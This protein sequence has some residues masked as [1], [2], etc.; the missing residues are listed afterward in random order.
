MFDE[1]EESIFQIMNHLVIQWMGVSPIEETFPEIKI[2]EIYEEVRE[3]DECDI[4]D[5]RDNARLE[6]E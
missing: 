2:E 6:K 3:S 4:S 1:S 5:K